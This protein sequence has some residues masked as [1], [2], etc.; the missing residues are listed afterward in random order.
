METLVAFLPLIVLVLIM[1]LLMIRPAQKRQKQMQE[2]QQSLE[3]GDTI[4]TIGGIHGTVE[5]HDQKH[6]YLSVDEG[7]GTVLKFDRVALKEI[8]RDNDR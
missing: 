1:Y 7:S 8:V 6:I 3:R 2:M 4:V 5:S